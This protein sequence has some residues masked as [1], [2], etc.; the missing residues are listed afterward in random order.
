MKYI[1]LLIIIVIFIIIFFV[2][3]YNENNKLEKKLL[4]IK[5]YLNKDKTLTKNI[6]DINS[7]NK[8]NKAEKNYNIFGGISENDEII[9]YRK[10]LDDLKNLHE[11]QNVILKKMSKDIVL[12]DDL[13]INYSYNDIL[14]EL[15]N[16]NTNKKEL[17]DYKKNIYDSIKSTNKKSFLDMYADELGIDLKDFKDKSKSNN[18]E[19]NEN[20][21]ENNNE[22]KSGII[23]RVTSFVKSSIDSLFGTNFSEINDNNI[24]TTKKNNNNLNTTEKNYDNMINNY[25]NKIKEELSNKGNAINVRDTDTNYR[26]NKLE[27]LNINDIK[28][29]NNKFSENDKNDKNNRQIDL[30]ELYSNNKIISPN[31]NLCSDGI[32]LNKKRYDKYD[33]L[34]LN[35]DNINK[36]NKKINQKK[37]LE[38]YNM[39][40]FEDYSCIDNE[41]DEYKDIHS[42]VDC[43]N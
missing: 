37:I 26:T 21:N 1:K 27:S 4:N 34:I 22:K 13:N 20:N 19:N 43:I 17:Y 32:Y 33:D 42:R 5:T 23:N 11:S 8:E 38:P 31:E 36:K 40:E 41:C 16:D 14:N 24:N 2:I 29:S 30:K 9:K 10:E 3:I 28:M 12:E 18:N 25:E 15:K 6:K 7:L 35:I 39:D